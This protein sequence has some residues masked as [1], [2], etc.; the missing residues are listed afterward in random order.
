M[1]IALIVSALGLG[2]A[3]GFHCIGMCGPI[4]LSMGLTRQQRTNFYLQNITYQLG[5]IVTYSLLGAILGI[6]GEGFEF[7]GFQRV[8]T[9]M[10]G[11]L[12]I[13]MSLFSF[14]KSDYTYRIP[15]INKL[16]QKLKANLGNILQKADYSSR[17]TTGLLNGFLPCG[18]VYMA[19]T[20]SI[21]SGGIWQGAVFMGL[22]GLGTFPF[23]FAV[24][25]FGNLIGHTFRIKALKVIPVFMVILGSLFIIRG[26]EIGI[27]YIS[28]NSKYMKISRKMNHE[29][30]IMH[31][32]EKNVKSHT[33]SCH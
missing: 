22:F 26:M 30:H 13:I 18:M 27:P 32:E 6:I 4:A 8:L 12:L 17:F 3:T 31:E 11:V 9:I 7:A 21:A 25:L 29:H 24:V 28:P 1:D 14:A 5:R 33:K 10:A 15:F 20:A 19:L 23:M 16:L 2:F